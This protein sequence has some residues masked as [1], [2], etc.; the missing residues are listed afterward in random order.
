ML[1]VCAASVLFALSCRGEVG[2]FPKSITRDEV[3][4]DF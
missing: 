4:G 2:G 3:T 1:A